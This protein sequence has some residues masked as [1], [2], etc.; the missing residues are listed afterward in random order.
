M[1]NPPVC[2]LSKNSDVD[3]CSKVSQAKNQ[4]RV[5]CLYVGTDPNAHLFVLLYRKSQSIPHIPGEV[6]AHL[7]GEVYVCGL[8]GAKAFGVFGRLPL[9]QAGM[10]CLQSIT[11]ARTQEVWSAECGVASGA[12]ELFARLAVCVFVCV[13]VCG[14]VCFSVCVVVCGYVR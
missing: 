5:S 11:D 14:W 2:L 1:R 9:A 3:L 8:C 10:C 7:I 6:K 4:S 13:C 12:M